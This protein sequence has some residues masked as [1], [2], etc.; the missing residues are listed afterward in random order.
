M[1]ENLVEASES[2]MA[3]HSDSRS[4]PE[5]QEHWLKCY[6]ANLG[7]FTMMGDLKKPLKP[8]EFVAAERLA[9]SFIPRAA[10]GQHHVSQFS[11]QGTLK[12]KTLN[13]RG[14]RTAPPSLWQGLCPA[15]AKL[16][17]LQAGAGGLTSLRPLVLLTF[18]CGTHCQPQAH[19]HGW[20]QQPRQGSEH[21]WPCRTGWHCLSTRITLGF[22]TDNCTM[23][24][25]LYA[26]NPC[27]VISVH[28]KLMTPVTFQ[29]SCD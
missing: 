13:G 18:Q 2:F 15:R 17:S 22:V 12:G 6:V 5:E 19:G 14:P 25:A 8:C 1:A 3:T 23:V 29:V 24:Y 11:I 4:Q 21:P 27:F 9:W 26:H 28:L 20:L 10:L 16:R 7:G